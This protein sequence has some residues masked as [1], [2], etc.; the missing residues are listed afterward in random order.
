MLIAH[1]CFSYCWAVR[2]GASG[3]EVHKKLGGETAKIADSHWPNKYSR[4]Y[5]KKK[6]RERRTGHLKLWHLSY[7]VTITLDTALLY[8]KQL[9]TQLLLHLLMYL[10]HNPQIFSLSLFMWISRCVEVSCLPRCSTKY[11]LKG[12]K[13]NWEKLVMSYKAISRI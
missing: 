3:M 9:H 5:E 12:K 1:R 4:L 13:E 2:V 6:P 8:W 11:L 10:Y 7:R